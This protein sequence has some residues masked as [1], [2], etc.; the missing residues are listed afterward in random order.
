MPFKKQF[1]YRF[2]G[3][4]TGRYGSFVLIHIM[5]KKDNKKKNAND[6]SFITPKNQKIYCA[7]LLCQTK[8]HSREIGLF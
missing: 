7:K 1:N 2:S 5:V 4:P 8:V 3:A 6:R